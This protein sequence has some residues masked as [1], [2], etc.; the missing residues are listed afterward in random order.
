MTAWFNV[1]LLLTGC[2]TEPVETE[3]TPIP[4]DPGE[5][6]V[7]T[8]TLD[9]G[10]LS[11]GDSVQQDLVLSNIGV[12]TLYVHD[13][14]LS[15]DQLLIHWTIGAD[16]EQEIAPGETLLIPVVLS[17]RD[18]GDPSVVLNV[19]S[20]DPTAPKIAVQLSAQVAGTPALR[21]DPETL[22]FGT[23]A[24]GQSQ[25][26]DVIM[27]NLGNDTL[28]I[29]S[30]TLDAQA[31]YSLTIDPSG[32]SLAPGQANGLASVTYSPDAPGGHTG[33]LTVLSNDPASP[34]LTVTLTG[35]GQ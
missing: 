11:L 4:V 30:V 5:L 28:T 32:S 35:T 1:A 3:P 15:D 26:L 21:L 25:T 34:E 23:L 19:L 24:V 13:L 31:G 33:L 12:G 18:L 10:T 6:H 27:S 16:V 20:S 9:F 17:P 14:Q 29:D 7:A 2:L 22:D 8:R